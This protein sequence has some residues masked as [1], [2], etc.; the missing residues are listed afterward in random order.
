MTLTFI[1]QQRHIWALYLN[2][3]MFDC[4]NGLESYFTDICGLLFRLYSTRQIRSEKAWQ[5]FLLPSTRRKIQE[6]T[7]F[8]AFRHKWEKI[9]LF[10]PFN[11]VM[12]FLLNS[13]MDMTPVKIRS[14]S[15]VVTTT[16]KVHNRRDY[17]LNN[18]DSKYY[19]F[20]LN[21]L[22]SCW[23]R[24]VSLPYPPSRNRPLA[25]HS[26]TPPYYLKRRMSTTMFLLFW[27]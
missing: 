19:S 10:S 3:L 14:N 8:F 7:Q 27:R 15:V 22:R 23:F 5:Y 16:P 11:F 20:L 13:R 26:Q 24:S 18:P 21:M 6:S 9:K 12:H 2:E 1:N 17:G 4:A 25:S